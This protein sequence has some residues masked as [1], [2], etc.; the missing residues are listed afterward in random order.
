MAK[1]VNL[2]NGPIFSSLTA[3]A[4][5]IMGSQLMQMA[6]N[7][8]DMLWIG[9]VGVGAM[10]AVGA[11]GLF[12]WLSNGLAILA[13]MGGQ[14]MVAQ[15]IGAGDM[16]K[17]G[18]YAAAALQLGGAL[19]LGYTLILVLGSGPLIGFFKLN[20]PQ[21][22]ADARIYLLLVAIGMPFSFINQVLVS[23]I[24]A[25]GN[26]RTP[27]IAMACGL[28]ANIVLDPLLIFGIHGV[29]RWGVA[30]A[31]LATT[32]AQAAVFLILYIYARRDRFFFPHVHLLQKTSGREL[33]NL[34]KISAPAAGLNV[35]FPI[36]NIILARMVA[37]FGDGAVAIQK[38]GGQ[39]ESIS[40]MTADGFAAAT[41]SFVG[42][43]YG[44]GKLRRAKKGVA[45]SFTLMSIWG[46][47]C[48]LLLVFAAKPIV[49]VFI[50]DPAVLPMGAEYLVIV[51]LSELFMCWE[52]LIEGAYAG[53]GHTLTPSI[54][55]AVVTVLR[56]PLSA[57]L[58][59][60]S[61][62]LNGIWWSISL[63]TI[64]K[65]ILLLSIFLLFLHS[66]TRKFNA[67]NGIRP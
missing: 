35:L 16:D 46:V 32:L 63:T 31:A 48:T 53:F 57:L 9:Q 40:W 49:R 58:S 38:V 62:G 39:V 24:T 10:A 13:R 18:R 52:I 60:T 11:V 33:R 26:S 12:M 50:S 42:Q 8:T 2:L 20:S 17:A 30:G 29:F 6:Y 4:L 21:V 67:R 28:G 43:N 23:V 45:V 15:N 1:H 27:F 22:I 59:T 55:S 54:L 41:N 44:A 61:L 51:G 14:V 3:L 37:A 34:L 25:T 47:L 65:G 5:P 7:L 64:F 19:A 56:I 36:I 66:L